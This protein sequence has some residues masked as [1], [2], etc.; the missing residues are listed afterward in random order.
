MKGFYME[1]SILLVEDDASDV[2]L[3][4]RAVKKLAFNARIL[5]VSDG[6]E[7]VNYLKG[8][9][10]YEDRDAYPVPT[11]ILL[12]IKL[13]GLSGFEVIEWLREQPLPL[14]RLPIVMLTSSGQQID[15]D[16]AYEL[17]ANSY[18]RKPDRHA[19]LIELLSS[20]NDFWLSRS[21]LPD[22]LTGLS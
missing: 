4:R 17:G 7:A 20:F 8:N 14:S 3:V 16:R 2:A 13:P 12:D 21:E 15:V 19:E 9:S 5:H 6:E 22:V 1:S 18:L 11:V 10:P